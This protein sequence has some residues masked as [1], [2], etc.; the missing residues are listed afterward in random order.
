MPEKF[1]FKQLNL[2]YQHNQ[3]KF[4]EKFENLTKD[5][6]ME[7]VDEARIDALEFPII[8]PLADYKNDNQD[9]R[10]AKALANRDKHGMSEEIIRSAIEKSV[11]KQISYGDMDYVKKNI[12]RFSTV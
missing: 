1:D 10:I 12:S 6:Q 4:D 11:I 3:D 7:V 5:E 2:S 8:E 9:D